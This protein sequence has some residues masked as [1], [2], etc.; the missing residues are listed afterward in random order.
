MLFIE[1]LEFIADQPKKQKQI[2]VE[3]MKKT[4]IAL[5]VVAGLT[6]F[7]GTA[8]ADITYYNTPYTLDA[9]FGTL[10]F[11]TDGTTFSVSSSGTYGSDTCLQRIYSSLD[12]V[13]D[14]TSSPL[15]YGT[16]IESSSSFSAFST[17]TPNDGY[18]GFRLSLGNGNYDYGWMYLTGSTF[19]VS[20]EALNNTPNQSI[21]AGQITAVPEPSTYAL[22]GLGALGLGMAMRRKK[23][24]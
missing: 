18:Y 15:A 16:T 19:T 21:T 4:I 22:C 10:Y 11:K 17:T 1:L 8:K 23:T 6:L 3:Y 12:F 9:N 24:A 5:A 2:K 14:F 13:G 7:A 20:S